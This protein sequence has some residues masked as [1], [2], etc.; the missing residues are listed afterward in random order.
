[1]RHKAKKKIEE[2]MAVDNSHQEF[3]EPDS[4]TAEGAAL[5]C[6]RDTGKTLLPEMLGKS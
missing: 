5:Y 4:Q 1:M 2:N 6:G 3:H